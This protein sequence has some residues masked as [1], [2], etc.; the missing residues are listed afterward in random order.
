MALIEIAD[1]GRSYPVT[2]LPHQREFSAGW[3]LM[4]LE[5]RTAIE[6]EIN[7]RL[8]ELTRTPDPNLG[9][10]YKHI[11]RGRQVQPHHRQTG[12]LVRYGIPSDIRSLP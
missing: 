5:Q 6:A 10:H 11:D 9:I 2:E 1:D 12:R 4:S 3:L 7:S 8:D